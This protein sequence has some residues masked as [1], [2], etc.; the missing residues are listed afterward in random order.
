M[1]FSSVSWVGAVLGGVAFF[2]VGGV[3]YGPLFGDRW[4]TETGMTPE[5]ARESNLALLFIG[6]LVLEIVAGV[7]L[8]AVMGTDVSPGSGLVAGVL[9]GLLL[10]APVLLVQAL[11]ERKSATL[12]ALNVGYNLVGFAVMG[13]IIALFQ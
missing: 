1:D 11:Y 4:M 12:W 10:A 2:A 3:W 13:V 5:R 6:T 9:V 7:G 8:A